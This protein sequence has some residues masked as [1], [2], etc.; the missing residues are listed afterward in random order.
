MRLMDTPIVAAWTHPLLS[1][2][3]SGTRLLRFK[4]WWS[5]HET[6]HFANLDAPWMLGFFQ[7]T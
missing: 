1:L 3:G 4:Q 7:A 6:D 5:G 2:L